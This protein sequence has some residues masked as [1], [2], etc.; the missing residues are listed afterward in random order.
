[1]NIFEKAVE[2]AEYHGRHKEERYVELL[3]NALISM[4]RKENPEEYKYVDNVYILEIYNDLYVVYPYSLHDY[5]ELDAALCKIL[6]ESGIYNHCCDDDIMWCE[7]GEIY[8][9]DDDELIYI[10]CEVYC[11]ECFVEA[12]KKNTDELQTYFEENHDCIY[13]PDGGD[14]YHLIATNMGEVNLDTWTGS[15][16]LG[17]KENVAKDG[18]YEVRFETY[19]VNRPARGPAWRGDVIVWASIKENDEFRPLTKAEKKDF[20]QRYMTEE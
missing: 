1:L 3:S 14:C 18:I 2:I 19:C 16:A 17:I 10:N 13:S 11:T 4:C 8:F 5:K 20:K 15:E 12:M 7:C 9:R 6:H